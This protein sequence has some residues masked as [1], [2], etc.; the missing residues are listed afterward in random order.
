MTV[1]KALM[2]LMLLMATSAWLTYAE[3]PTQGNLKRAIRDTF[4]LL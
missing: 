2:L 3:R 1:R 4:P